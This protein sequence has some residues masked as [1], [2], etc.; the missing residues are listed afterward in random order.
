MK[1]TFLCACAAAAALWT[2][3]CAPSTPESRIYESPAAFEALSAKHKDLVKRGEIA[4]GM[5]K[6]AVALAWGSPSGTV[7][8]FRN[9][10]NMERWEYQGQ[11]PVVTNNFF[12]GYR[13]GYYGGYRYSG[14]GGGFGPQVTYV[15]YRKNVVWFVGGRVDEWESVR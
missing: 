9:G 13:T 5:G 1:T 7:D 10:R 4:K 14:L 3:S 6:D 11:R 12:G 15:P 8:G 2:V